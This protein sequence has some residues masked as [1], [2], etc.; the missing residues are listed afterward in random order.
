MSRPFIFDRMDLMQQNQ[1][2]MKRWMLFMAGE[3]D[4]LVSAYPIPDSGKGIKLETPP[5]GK[6][7]A[8][9]LF[10]K[11]V[12]GNQILVTWCRPIIKK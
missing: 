5:R 9:T 4:F 2:A 3:R 6:G 11:E 12:V 8:W 1:E 10:D 7:E